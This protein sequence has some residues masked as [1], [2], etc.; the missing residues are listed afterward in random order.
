M[1]GGYNLRA[2]LRRSLS[3]IDEY[4]WEVSLP[5]V[6]EW[7]AG[8][9]KRQYPELVE[10][11]EE[12][13]MI[14]EHEEKKYKETMKKSRTIVASLIKKTKKIDFEHMLRLYESD[15]ITPELVKDV[16]KKENVEVKVPQDFY[17]K[18]SVTHET[19]KLEA[20]GEKFNID[21]LQPT[22]KLY[23]DNISEFTATIVRYWAQG[24]KHY[25]V[26]D[27]SAFY[28]ESGGQ[29][30]DSG[31]I[32]GSKIEHVYKAGDAIVHQVEGRFEKGK[33][34]RGRID[35]DKRRQL[36][37]HHTA[38][39]IINGA[40]R[41]VLGKHVWQ[42]GSEKTREK[43]RLDI[44]HYEQLTGEQLKKIEDLANKVVKEKRKVIKEVLSRDEAE[45]RY[46]FRIYQ[47]GAIPSNDIRIVNIKDWDIEACGGTHADNTGEVGP[48]KIIGSYKKQDGVI[49]LEYVAGEELIKKHAERQKEAAE[50]DRGDWI[51]EIADMLKELEKLGQ[52]PAKERL[53]G[54]SVEDLI[55]K[56][57]GLRKE[58]ER[59]KQKAAGGI[60]V[61]GKVQY[62]P[63]ADMGVLQNIGR[64]F[65]EEKPKECVVLVSDGIV[66]GIRGKSCRSNIEKAVKEAASIMGGS[67]GGKEEMKGG[68]PLKDKGGAAAE[69]AKRLLK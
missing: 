67:A 25:L 9:W 36:M 60:E 38:T 69:K 53:E 24:G 30:F 2:I 34:V 58:I 50:K 68:G 32:D 52:K 59:V 45:R 14:L 46:G 51:R 62:I 10:S 31:E 18:V 7:H 57:K 43:A 26:L 37:M 28:P 61:T 64:K 47:G 19:S 3:F 17:A 33:T 22:K 16:A 66:F 12:V 23:Y 49:R 29:D 8:E 1:G 35:M 6:C 63:G 48:I 4:E 11:L 56:W 42:T 20:K 27:Q 41:T 39:H 5:Q 13:K 15:G 21:G 40:A 55:D 44:T 65:V 54:L